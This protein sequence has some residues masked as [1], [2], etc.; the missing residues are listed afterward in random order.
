MLIDLRSAPRHETPNAVMRTLASPSLGSTELAVW[1][2]SME[3]GQQGPEHK[4]DREQVWIVLDGHLDVEMAGESSCLKEGAA[5]RIPPEVT[6]QVSA[7][8]R[9][10]ALVASAAG[11][12]VTP[13]G[14][15]E[16]PLPWA[17]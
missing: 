14:G 13:S 2:V 17:S 12:L 6:R 11:S 16:R 10:H 4:V 3:A 8:S 5:L 1:H 15:E 7:R 9:T